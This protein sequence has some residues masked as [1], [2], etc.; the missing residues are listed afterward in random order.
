[1]EA[2][3]VHQYNKEWNIA[4]CSTVDGSTGYDARWNKLVREKYHMILVINVIK[5]TKQMYKEKR[6][7]PKNSLLTIENKLVFARGEVGEVWVK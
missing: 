4:I 7:K 6:D 1:M 3:C 5:D 2:T